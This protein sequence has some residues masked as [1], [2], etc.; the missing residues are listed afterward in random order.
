MCEE[1]PG[2]GGVGSMVRKRTVKGGFQVYCGATEWMEQPFTKDG[3]DPGE[4]TGLDMKVTSET[5]KQRCSSH[6]TMMTFRNLWKMAAVNVKKTKKKKKT[7]CPRTS[8]RP[9]STFLHSMFK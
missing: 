8:L 7:V 3:R 5:S 1:R 4:D 9:Y 6:M 2:T